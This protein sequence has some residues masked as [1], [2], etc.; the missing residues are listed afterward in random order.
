MQK[1]ICT[2]AFGI[3]AVVLEET[4]NNMR[5]NI[6]E[7]SVYHLDVFDEDTIFC[8]YQISSIKLLDGG[9]L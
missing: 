3:I 1:T 5:D 8:L 6:F 4:K 7:L 2:I 9:I